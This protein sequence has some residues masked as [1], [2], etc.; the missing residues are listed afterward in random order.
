MKNIKDICGRVYSVKKK[1]VSYLLDDPIGESTLTPREILRTMWSLSTPA[2]P[3]LQDLEQKVIR[4]IESVILARKEPIKVVKE[5]SGRLRV[6]DGV[7]RL[8]KAF[9]SGSLDIR[10]DEIPRE[11]LEGTIWQN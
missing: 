7:Y 10:V 9:D 11:K 4:H 6:V 1:D 8:M 3:D 5:E 2:G